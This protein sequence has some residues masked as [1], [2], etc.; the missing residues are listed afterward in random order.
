MSSEATVPPSKPA[1][2]LGLTLLVIGLTFAL[3]FSLVPAGATNA[4][5][6]HM[7]AEVANVYACTAWAGWAHFIFAFWG[8]GGALIRLKDSLRAKRTITY[9]F[10]IVVS[11][12]M[13]AGLRSYFGVAAFGA[14]VWVYFIDHFIKAEQTFEGSLDPREP[15]WRR[16]VRSYQILLS[17]G[18]LTAVLMNVASVNS[19]PW[20]LWVISLSLA[21]VVLVLG[22]WRRLSSGDS[23][24]PLISLFFL[25]E[26]LVWGTF[27]RYGGPMFLTG[28]YVFHIAAGSYVHYL[29]SYFFAGSRLAGARPAYGL[30]VLGVNAA[31]LGLGYLTVQ[32]PFMAWLKPVLG[33]E[34]FT[35]WVA[36]HLVASDVFP[37]IK[38]WRM[39]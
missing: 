37:A 5:S 13:L 27:S 39:G 33:V 3:P 21:A 17:F 6:K 16:W 38:A 4:V 9:V 31:I 2:V 11:V 1:A 26:A 15:S 18:W 36:L 30:V 14:V 7:S 8:Q 24:G 12:A 35:L 23:R 29:G 34:W 32:Q 10:M 22:G 19:Y 28:V 25:A 20:T